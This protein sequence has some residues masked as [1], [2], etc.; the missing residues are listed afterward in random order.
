MSFEVD[1]LVLG[2]GMAGLT[3]GAYAAKQG[4][5]VLVLERAPQLGGNAALAMGK[6]WTARDREWMRREN[7]G[8]SPELAEVLIEDFPLAL[9]WI[10][11]TGTW[12]SEKIE[13]LHGEGFLID[14]QGYL[15]RCRKIIEGN[16]GSL[17]FDTRV[18]DLVLDGEG[19]VVGARV[20]ESEACVTAPWTVLATGGFQGN[21][22]LLGRYFGSAA[23]NLLLR[24]NP[25]SQG[26]GL[27]LGLSAG[28]ERA[29]IMDTY[30]GHLIAE[31]LESFGPS[32]FLRLSMKFSP[33]GILLNTA[34]RRFTDE[35]L[36]DHFNAQAVGRQSEGRALLVVDDV[37]GAE[38]EGVIKEA[39]SA[40]AHVVT[41]GSLAGLAAEVGSWGYDALQAPAE[42]QRFN[43]AMG[44]GPNLTVGRRSNR[45]GL[46]SGPWTAMEVRSGIT[47]TNGGLRVD[48]TARV[49]GGDGPIR[50]LLAAGAD[51][52]GV[53]A[54]GYA[55][56]LSFAGI[57][58]LR[59]SRFALSSLGL[60]PGPREA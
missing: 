36:G 38:N 57:Y 29:G 9:D 54:G 51:M 32:E 56:G 16:G 52:G 58:G 15:T 1:L 55:G 14:I 34:G 31:P 46:S 53:Y 49:L 13:V 41:A 8:G 44:G 42:I 19:S 25:H 48:R 18:S 50:G 10:R 3:A 23:E 6:F 24:A 21:R 40:G 39:A 37:V 2:A 30:Y 7:P 11:S 35:S 22:E 45:R 59:A 4:A 28:G 5:S 12:V 33:H 26:D 27:R 47:F 20:L 17:A 60:L 43:H